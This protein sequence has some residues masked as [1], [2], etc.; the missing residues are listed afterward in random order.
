VVLSAC[1]S[2]LG[3]AVN[4]EGVYGM[5]RALQ[6]AGARS[7]VLS[8]WPVDDAATMEFMTGFYGRVEEGQGMSEAL[9]ATKLEMK[10]SERYGDT[11]YW[12]PFVLAGEWK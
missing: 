7:Q 1:E 6:L 2:G 9:R 10:N 5:R 11:R 12:A 8:L 3:D 4:G